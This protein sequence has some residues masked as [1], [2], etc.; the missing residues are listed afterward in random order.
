ML[1]LIAGIFI[2]VALIIILFIVVRKFPALAMLD[3]ATIPGEKEAKFKEQLIRQR[4]ERDLAQIAG[5]LGRFWLALRNF[6]GNFLESQQKNLKK[7]KAGYEAV[8]RLPGQ[9][10]AQRLR[11]LV[12]EAEELLKKEEEGAA[13]EKLLEIIRLDRHNLAAFTDLA[14][15]YTSQK[16]WPEARQTYEYAVKLA[17]RQT[18][19]IPPALTVQEV[20]FSWGEMEAAADNLRTALDCVQEAL[21][22]EPNSPRY[23]DLIIDLSIMRKDKSL[24]RQ[25]W[26][27]LAAVN[28]DN[29]KLGEWKEKIDGLA[30]ET[31]KSE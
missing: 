30:D 18:D 6:L 21:E 13:E 25:Y 16:K 11:I 1:S 9:E 3:V 10:K 27:R 12:R 28:P 24:A 5:W 17:K 20:Y 29:Q 23:L 26:E 4:V 14:G 15:L 31:E 8:R 7:I 2:V 19:P 22:R